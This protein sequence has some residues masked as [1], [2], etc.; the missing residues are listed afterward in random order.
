MEDNN[1]Q[2]YLLTAVVV[3]VGVWVGY[4]FII[5][6]LIDA[7]KSRQKTISALQEDVRREQ[8]LAGARGREFKDRWAMMQSNALPSDLSQ[9]QSEVVKAVDRWALMSGVTTES[10]SPQVRSDPDE[11]NPNITITTVECRVDA[12]G[13]MNSILSFLYAIGQEKMGTKLDNVELATKDNASQQMTVGLT[14]SAL[15][16]G[17][18]PPNTTA[19]AAPKAET[20]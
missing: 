9:A 11:T 7:W 1:R 15:V 2:K 17:V 14:I 6:P 5:T 20:E 3:I 16:L 4:S 18:P 10:I 8:K 13:N 19:P 12:T